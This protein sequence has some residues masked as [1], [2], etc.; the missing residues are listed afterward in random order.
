MT[1][2]EG[3][4][5]EREGKRESEGGPAVND[6]WYVLHQYGNTNTEYPGAVV[7]MAFAHIQV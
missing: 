2:E 4:P 7:L 6:Q 1:A 5:R 3:G